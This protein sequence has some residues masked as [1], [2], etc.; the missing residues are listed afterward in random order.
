[1]LE[2]TTSLVP[3]LF[4]L[5]LLCHANGQAQVNTSSSAQ[6]DA[7]SVLAQLVP[8]IQ[9]KDLDA[10]LKE[11]PEWVTSETAQRALK[12]SQAE[13]ATNF[14]R[15]LTYARIAH[16]LSNRLNDKRLKVRSLTYLP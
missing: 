10:A 2:R 16:S 9:D 6:A 13:L 12:K 4:L 8:V 11:H 1:M 3:H 7:D 5:V 14:N 15:A